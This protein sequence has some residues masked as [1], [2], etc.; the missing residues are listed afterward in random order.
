MYIQINTHVLTQK[1]KCIGFN[2]HARAQMHVNEHNLQK[3]YSL[4]KTHLTTHMHQHTCNN[5][6]KYSLTLTKEWM[7]QKRKCPNK[8]ASTAHTNTN[9]H[10]HTLQYTSFHITHISESD[11]RTNYN[12]PIN[13][14]TKT[15]M[16]KYTQKELHTRSSMQVQTGLRYNALANANAHTITHVRTITCKHYCKNYTRIY[17][18]NKSCIGK[19]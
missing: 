11:T 19:K 9:A 1:N 18:V 5:M 15:C 3:E 7:T 13:M 12:A 8:H 14:H 17:S 2:M 6:Y 16:Q 4:T 10:T